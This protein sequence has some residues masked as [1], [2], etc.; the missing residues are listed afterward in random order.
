MILTRLLADH[1]LFQA[2][3]AAERVHNNLPD[4]HI[5]PQEKLPFCDVPRVVGDR[6]GNIAFAK[7]GYGDDGDGATFRELCR[8]LINTGEVGVQ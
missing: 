8:F 5:F 1:E 4:L 7:G 2:A 6:V 3:Q